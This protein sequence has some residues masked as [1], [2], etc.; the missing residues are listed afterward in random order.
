MTPADPTIT[1]RT[2]TDADAPV[3]ARL[4]ALD[5]TATIHLPALIAEQDG[6]PVAARSLADGL[7]AADPFT[8]VADIVE[9]LELRAARLTGPPRHRRV[10]RMRRGRR[11]VIAGA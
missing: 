6:R 8:R 1:I 10:P 7:V 4:A 5:E 2:A 11:A 3:L 9:L